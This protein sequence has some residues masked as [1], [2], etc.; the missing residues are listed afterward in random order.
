[1]ASLPEGGTFFPQ[2]AAPNWPDPSP[3][4]GAPPRVDDMT[5]MN[6]TEVSRI[7]CVRTVE[8]IK[9][10]LV[11]ACEHGKHVSI[12]GTRHSMGGHTI[13]DGGY[14]IDMMKLNKFNFDQT[15]ELVTAQAGTLWSDLITGLNPY[16]Y[17][18]RTMQSYSTCE[19][20]R[21]AHV[22]FLQF[23]SLTS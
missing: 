17:S 9:A 12:R 1:M 23:A 22:H 20:F 19:Y 13:A 4:I 6:A 8:D 15:A 21:T 18:P 10:V 7:F 11:L 5:Q 3:T 14:V 16:G 2:H